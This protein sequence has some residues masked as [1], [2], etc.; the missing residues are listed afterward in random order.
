MAALLC[1]LPDDL[2][3]FPTSRSGEHA[4]IGQGD[5]DSHSRPAAV[6]ED[7]AQEQPAVPH[8]TG[9]RVSQDAADDDFADSMEGQWELLKQLALER[10]REAAAERA[11]NEPSA[12][13]ADGV[14]SQESANEPAS[15][16]S[17]V[18]AVASS[19]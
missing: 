15:W 5:A 9:E 1:A 4:T 6:E 11:L 17:I 10:H 18:G 14:I 8:D 19:Y 2:L 16:R 13:D 7:A 12:S 3:L